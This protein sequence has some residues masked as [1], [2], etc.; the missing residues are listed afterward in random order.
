MKKKVKK[1]LNLPQFLYED[2]GERNQ[3]SACSPSLFYKQ[4]EASRLC[5]KKGLNFEFK[6]FFLESQKNLK[7]ISKLLIFQKMDQILR[8][9]LKD[10]FITKQEREIL[11]HKIDYALEVR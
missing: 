1:Y 7:V 10:L 9:E 11:S 4:S 3:E 6:S 2:L 5:R 8:D